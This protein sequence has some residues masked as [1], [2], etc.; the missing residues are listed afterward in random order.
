MSRYTD[1]Q[2]VS[3]LSS[4]QSSLQTSSYPSLRELLSSMYPRQ[5]L[6]LPYPYLGILLPSPVRIGVCL[7]LGYDFTIDVIPLSNVH[8]FYYT[9]DNM[10]W[11]HTMNTPSKLKPVI[12]GC[13]DTEPFKSTAWEKM[14]AGGVSVE[15]IRK[16]VT[17][18]VERGVKVGYV[19]MVSVV[20]EV[21]QFLKGESEDYDDD[22]DNDDDDDEDEDDDDEGG[23]GATEGKEKKGKKGKKSSNAANNGA[24]VVDDD[25]VMKNLLLQ[26]SLT[27]TQQD[28][29]LADDSDEEDF[30][31][32]DSFVPDDTGSRYSK[33]F[34]ELRQLGAGGGGSV[35][36]VRKERAIVCVCVCVCV[37]GAKDE[38]TPF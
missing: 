27:R 35:F 17:E 6:P 29:G 9:D 15:K 21:E 10:S 20:L 22:D 2:D 8:I 3:S 5:V 18:N 32:D 4:P 23:G 19:D 14:T 24:D 36:K 26:Q 11:V 13:F 31:S 33:D 16:V 37:Q 1:L 12:E 25:E 30:D 34:K 38:G 28:V 7:D